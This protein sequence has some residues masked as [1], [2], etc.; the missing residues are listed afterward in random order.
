M[1]RYI[2]EHQTVDLGFDVKRVFCVDVKKL[3]D[4]YNNLQE[5]PEGTLPPSDPSIPQME[6]E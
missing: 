3:Q 4:W 6:K 5:N 2:E 1:K